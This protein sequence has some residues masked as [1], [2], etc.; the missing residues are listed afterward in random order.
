LKLVLIPIIIIIIAIAGYFAFNFYLE[1]NCFD[2][3]G[4][5]YYVNTTTAGNY[6]PLLQSDLNNGFL[7]VSEFSKFSEL[8]ENKDYLARHY[9]NCTGTQHTYVVD[10]SVIDGLKGAIV[11]KEQMQEFL[12]SYTRNPNTCKNCL[13][14]MYSSG[15]SPIF[16][17]EYP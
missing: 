6:F 4:S 3:A 9:W 8:W 10:Y 12:D 1:T 5:E 7:D 14:K 2:G 17:E 16:V 15:N 11:S 13:I